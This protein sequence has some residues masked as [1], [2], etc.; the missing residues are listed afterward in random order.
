MKTVREFH[1]EIVDS[2]SDFENQLDSFAGRSKISQSLRLELRLL[3]HEL[4]QLIELL[5]ADIPSSSPNFG[6]IFSIQIRETIAKIKVRTSLIDFGPEV[7]IG[8]VVLE[9]RTQM[10]FPDSFLESKFAKKKAPIPLTKRERDVLLLLPKGLSAKGM[11]TELF[12]TEATIKTHLASIFRKFDV[13]NRIQAI[14]IGID[15]KYL[16]F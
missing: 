5:G 6:T 16:T 10:G 1:D 12:L 13:T 8:N 2:L 11:A 4:S 3:R 7:D 14:A 15:S 9:I